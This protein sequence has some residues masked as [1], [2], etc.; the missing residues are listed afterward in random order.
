MPVAF[1]P[2]L[3]N[4]PIKAS[5]VYWDDLYSKWIGN[6]KFSLEYAFCQVP[7]EEEVA[8]NE[9]L[10]FNTEAAP[11]N[12][13]LLIS[14]QDLDSVK[15]GIPSLSSSM[16]KISATPSPSESRQARVELVIA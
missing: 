2:S 4:K 16:S 13:K 10:V 1:D 15:S 6:A 7:F 9:L 11:L 8:I 3:G 12:V 5:G 14:G